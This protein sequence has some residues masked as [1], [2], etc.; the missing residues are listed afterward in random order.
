[1][2]FDKKSLLMASILL[3][4]LYGPVTAQEATSENTEAAASSED[5][6]SD[7]GDQ[8][9]A[10]DGDAA[11]TDGE[12]VADLL[13]DEELDDLVAPI[14]LYPDT[15]LIQIL[16]AATYPI[17]VIKANRFVETNS[18]MEQE[19]LNEA[20]DGEGWD[21]SVNVLAQGFPDVLANMAEHIDWT[22]LAGSAMLAQSEDVM[23]SVQRMR[24]QA[25]ELGNLETTEEQV[26]SRDETDA[27][28]IAPADPQVV[29]VPTY[30]TSTVY[31]QPNTALVFT[32]GII[33]GSIWANNNRWNNYWGCRNC[34]GWN[35]GNIHHRP[36]N[37]NVNGNVNIG[38]NV[39]VGNGNRGNGNWSP[40]KNKQTRAKNNIS[41][42]KSSGRVGAGTGG[43][44]KRPIDSSRPSRGDSMRRDL[45][46]QSGARDI[47]RPNA[48]G[49]DRARPA[50]NNGGKRPSTGA[51]SGNRT[52]NKAN[53][54]TTKKPK[55]SKPS[56][57][58]QPTKKPTQK[59]SN[60]SMQSHGGGK[61]ARSSKSRGS[62]SHSRSR[63]GGGRSRGGGGRRR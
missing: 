26:V 4:G 53:R 30:T 52:P 44:A 24:E 10:D 16:V 58:R 20:I 43:N 15:L 13:T 14:A 8:A 60:S 25:D 46:N 17:D 42:R 23:D 3:I 2:V 27:I 9:A 19:A 54:S 32:T 7:D 63:G 1:M 31:Y 62:A 51:A 55:A 59:R 37:I 22:E 12:E 6:T 11:D 33:I 28:I 47:S 45:S 61:A 29:Y 18:E 49:G 40:D 57:S 48:G 21:A 36:N 50:T 34:G 38:N 35:G 41:D 56:A 39:N 5:A